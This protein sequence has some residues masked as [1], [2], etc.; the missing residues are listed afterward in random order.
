MDLPNV[1]KHRYFTFVMYFPFIRNKT[2]IST[3]NG[4]SG[5]LIFSEAFQNSQYKTEWTLNE[6]NSLKMHGRLTD[7]RK[8]NLAMEKSFSEP[9]NS[10]F[11][12]MHRLVQRNSACP[13]QNLKIT[14]NWENIEILI[15]AEYFREIWYLDESF[16]KY[17]F[18]FQPTQGLWGGRKY[19]ILCR[20]WGILH[21]LDAFDSIIIQLKI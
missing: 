16:L 12:E 21:K 4:N 19:T 8:Q 6:P 10:R 15:L 20:N 11:L 3:A 14:S 17:C 1:S 18:E 13:A 9:N 2:K 7:L 5:I